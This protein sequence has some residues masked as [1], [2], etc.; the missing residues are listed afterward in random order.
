M[1]KFEMGRI[2]GIGVVGL[3]AMAMLMLW[4]A[5]WLFDPGQPH[6]TT[7][8]LFDRISVTYDNYMPPIGVLIAA[9]TVAMVFVVIGVTVERTVTNHYRRS[10]KPDQIPL[11]PRVVMAE[12]RGV[13]HGEVTITVLV[14]AH[15]EEE[16]ISA[17]I[18]GLMSQNDPPERIIV[19]ADNCTDATPD[20]ARAAGVEVFET[21]NNKAKKAGGLNQALRDLLPTLGDNDVVMIVDA[22]TVLDQGFLTEARRR[23]TNDRALMAVGGLFYGEPGAGWLGQ[24]QRNE[25]TR[26]SRDIRRRQGRVFVLT[27]TSSAFRS[28]ALRTVA[29]SRGTLLPGR[30]G[31]V[32]DTAALTED[33]E[34]TLALKSLGGLMVS[35]T[36]CSVVTEV[37]PTWKELWHQ[38]LRWQRGALENL[39]AY[40]VTPQT[41]RYWFQQLGI[42]YGAV[43]LFAYFAV[44]AIT[45]LAHGQWVWYP[46]WMSLGMAFMIERLVTVWRSTWFARFVAMLLI[47]EL[48]YATFLNIVFLKGVLDILLAKQASWGQE[49][50]NV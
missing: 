36:E 27:G 44:I 7:A 40:G 41:T 21:V 1:N 25:Y 6:P 11:A 19:V 22:D 46:Y 34:L 8:R 50:E 45:L 2:V 42:G 28:R 16:R 33:N 17:T 14:P 24:Y 31:D 4:L 18:E 20:L 5:I 12:T 23:F 32:Y 13:F 29:E 15:N 43:A 49:V 30:K 10:V 3:A 9:V 35:P 47:P 37:M 38:R 39:G 48:I 26:Y